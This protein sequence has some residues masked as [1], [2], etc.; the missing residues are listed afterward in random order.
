VRVAQYNGLEIQIDKR[1]VMR[2]GKRPAMKYIQ[3]QADMK[4]EK[5]GSGVKNA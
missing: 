3:K 2:R 5:L 1:L 4:N